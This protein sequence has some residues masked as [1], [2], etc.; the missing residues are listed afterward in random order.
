[1]MVAISIRCPHS[2]RRL[3]ITARLRRA[4]RRRGQVEAANKFIDEE[5]LHALHAGARLTDAQRDSVVNR[6]ATLTGLS[7]A[8]CAENNLRINAGVFARSLLA[9]QGKELGMYDGRYTLPLASSGKDP[10][11]DDP[12]MGQYVPGFVAATTSMHAMSLASPSTI[13]TRPS[14]SVR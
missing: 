7:P 1:M 11:A 9:D 12:A 6:L 8:S 13:P 3:A 10:V 5:Y 14:H 4:A 2:R